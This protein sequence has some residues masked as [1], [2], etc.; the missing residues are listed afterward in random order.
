MATAPATALGIR[1]Y[2]LIADGLTCALIGHDGSIGWL[3]APRF[4]SGSLFAAL[5][6][7]DR[8][9]QL[10]WAPA[11]TAGGSGAEQH[12][13]TGT[14]ILVTEI[15]GQVRI[16]DWMPAR[17]DGGSAAGFGNGALC[18][19]AEAIGGEIELELVCQPRP[20]YGAEGVEWQQQKASR[21]QGGASLPLWA[22]ASFPLS[23]AEGALRGRVRLRPGEAAWFVLAWGEAPAELDT[24]RVRGSLDATTRLWEA[25]SARAQYQGPY[26]DA[27]VRS[28]LALK[29][30]IYAPSGAMVAAATA[31]LPEAIGGPRNWDYR[32]CWP[33]DATFA[34]YGLSLLGY[35]DEAGR[36]LE[37]LT[38]ICDQNPPPLQV[39][40][41][42]DGGTE[43][44]ERELEQ[45]R[46]YR[47]SRPV[48]IGNAAAAQHQLDIY[49]EVMDAAYTYAKWRNGIDAGQWKA[50]ARLVDYAA[51]HW[52]DPD[53]SIWEVRGG[54][55]Q[56][57]YSKVLCWVALDRGIKIAQ[58]HHLP[59]ALADWERTRET[60][61]AEVLQRG[62]NQNIHAFTQKLDGDKLDSSLLLLP[63]LRFCS[64]HEP[65]MEATIRRI[66]E[67][68]TSDSL[69][70]RY[71][72]TDED[73]V[74]G[75]EGAFS[76]CTYWLV[77]C[78]TLL[79][80][81]DESRQLFERMRGYASPVGLFSEE[82]DPGSGHLLGNY[83]QAFTHMAL[84][85][86]AHNLLLYPGGVK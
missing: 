4:D 82:V 50:L 25:W 69:V 23:R 63:L 34:L 56:F 84:L 20:E 11:G 35:H 28:A 76:I 77:D 32:Y 59:A 31:S 57:T 48:R 45:L 21:W 26:R 70:A 55:R 78:L 46:G 33:R 12:Y 49:G 60:I 72:N 65:R 66:Q 83:P 16:T 13:R 73:G 7:P 68:L 3:C 27:V 18:R 47:D 15:A 38:R 44:A 30:L 86:S 42:V 8:A 2:G 51:A 79:G 43:V 67:R 80:R 6:D 40:Y 52:R 36:F 17:F 62:Y 54:P 85:N 64:P 71:E 41:R 29:A 75:P 58:R 5:L 74:G 24:A 39:C 1:D 19:C 22:E 61:R 53:E 10:R 9:G 81:S 14:N 37:F